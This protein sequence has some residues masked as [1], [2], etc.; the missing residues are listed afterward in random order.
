MEQCHV[1]VISGEKKQ[2]AVWP[3][4]SSASIMHVPTVPSLCTQKYMWINGTVW[5]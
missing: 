4:F 2:E 5:C 1:C 3:Y